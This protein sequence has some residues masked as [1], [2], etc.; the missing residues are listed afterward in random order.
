MARTVFP[1]SY[2]G[3]KCAARPHHAYVRL[4]GD[5]DDTQDV[6]A[7]LVS[8]HGCSAKVMIIDHDD[9]RLVPEG[10]TAWKTFVGTLPDETQLIYLPGQLSMVLRLDEDYVRRYPHHVHVSSYE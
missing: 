10:V 7:A 5:L 3:E 9:M 8:L 6:R 2:S 4:I 1:F